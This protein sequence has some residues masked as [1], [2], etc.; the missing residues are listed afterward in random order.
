[1]AENHDHDHAHYHPHSPHDHEHLSGDHTHDHLTDPAKIKALLEF[2]IEHNK[3]HGEEIADLAH[4]LYHAG[5]NEA[6]DLLGNGVKDFENGN[7]KLI[8]ALAIL[9]GGKA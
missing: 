6:A 8:E 9:S 7:E 4:S 2:M 5:Q 1:M 3:Q